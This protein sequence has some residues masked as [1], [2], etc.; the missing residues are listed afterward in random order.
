M[1]LCLALH[2]QGTSF[3]P[4][5]S[6]AP[7]ECRQWMKSPSPSM[8]EHLLPH[9]GHDA[10]ADDD[11]GRIGELHADMRDR[12][13]ERPHAEGDDVHGAARACSP[14]TSRS[15]V[16]RISFGS[17]QL[18]V[19]PASSLC[20][21]ADEGAVL[22]ARDVAGIGAGRDR[23][24]DALVGLSLMSVPC[25]T[26]S[27]QSRSYSSLRAVA[28]MNAI[29]LALGRDLIDPGEQLFVSSACRSAHAKPPMLMRG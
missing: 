4:S 23:N 6:G 9:A 28:P 12:R 16:A 3:W 10:H 5:A 19:G 22:D 11:I 25:A 15:S 8:I 18:L 14:R 1:Y 29:R 17:I 21:G 24:S 2:G 20:V 26:I 13:T 7:T 27:A